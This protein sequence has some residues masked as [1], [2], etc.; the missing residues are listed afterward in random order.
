MISGLNALRQGGIDRAEFI[1][2]L[3]EEHA[4]I[5]TPRT[6]RHEGLHK[7]V[8]AGWWV[9]VLVKVYGGRSGVFVVLY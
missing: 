1:A 7:V 2:V 6:T 9:V 4:C 8:L 3:R 5:T